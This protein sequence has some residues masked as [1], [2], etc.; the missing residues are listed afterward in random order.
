[1]DILKFA[2]QIYW[3]F[4]QI[5]TQNMNEIYNIGEYILNVVKIWMQLEKGKWLTLAQLYTDCGR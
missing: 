2:N 5:I 1:M 4:F 3:Y